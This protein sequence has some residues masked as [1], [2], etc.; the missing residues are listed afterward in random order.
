MALLDIFDSEQGRLGLGLLAMA[1]PSRMSDGERMLG[2]LQMLDQFKAQRSAAEERKADREER[3]RMRMLQEQQIQM[4]LEAARRQQAQAEAAAR[5]QQDFISQLPNPQAQAMGRIASDEPMLGGG[6]PASSVPSWNQ[7]FLRAGGQTVDPQAQLMYEAVRTGQI[8]PVDYMKSLQPKDRKVKSIETLAG[9]N[10][11]PVP[12]AVYEDGTTS[13]LPFGAKP[14]TVK[15]EPT[16]ASIREYEFARGQGYTGSFEDWTKQK[17]AGNAVQVSF[18]TGLIPVIG[19]DGQP[20]LA[21]ASNRGGA[22][23]VP[24]MKPMPPGKGNVPAEIRRMDIAATTMGNL[25][26]EYEAFLKTNNPRD[27]LVQMNS[28]KRAD[29]QSLLKNI[30]LQF[31][32]LQGLGALAGPDL[33]IMEAAITDPFTFKG[34]YYGSGGL[35]AQIGR[36]RQLIEERRRA[37]QADAGAA[38]DQPAAPAVDLQSLAREELR[39]RG[40]K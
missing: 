24:G 9:P 30:Q 12:V 11:Q 39:R 21:Q 7:A 5:N 13:V 6:S 37:M 1:Q 2:A 27:P 29:A 34:A 8:S 33:S 28:A 40:I 17:A 14:E 18:G 20:A 15:P 35:L 25:L 36:A 4:Q 32:E 26:N 23:I 22:Q 16:P 31:K 19:P 10:G 38:A 3:A